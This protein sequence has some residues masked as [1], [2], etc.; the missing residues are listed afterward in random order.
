MTTWTRR[1]VAAVATV[2]V[3][4]LLAPAAQVSAHSGNQ[5]YLY[6]DVTERT[7]GGRIEMPL[8]DLRDTLGVDLDGSNDDIEASLAAAA[9]AIAAFL[10]EHFR[11]GTDGGRWPVTYGTPTVFLSDLPEAD[12]RY[13][14]VDFDVDTGGGEVP[15]RFDVMFDPFLTADDAGDNLL[16]IANDWAGGVIENG[17]RVLLAFTEPGTTRTVDLGDASWTNTFEESLRLGVDHIRTGPDHILFV[18]VLLLPSVLVWRAAWLPARSFGA[19]LW[20]ITKIVTMFT[21]AHT[22]TF[23]LA[24]LDV[25]PLPPSKLTESII[26]LSIAAAAL[27]NLR[28]I[29]TNKEWSIAFVFGLFHGMGFAGLVGDLDV[30]RWTQLLSLAGR[31]L[32]IELGQTVVVLV[33]FPMLFLLRRT[34]YYRH[35]L[36]VGS[37]GLAIVSLGWLIERVFEVDLRVGKVVDPIVAWPRSLVAMVILTAVAAV[38]RSVEE[39]AGRLLPVD[40]APVVEEEPPLLEPVPSA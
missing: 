31:N 14:V 40:G 17:E 30:S 16:L 12:D 1:L 2:L 5:S 22:I 18:L 24:G 10:D 37:V 23:S 7:L 35:L 19:S 11:I 27:H 32:G 25:L 4:V 21:L 36:V 39:R 3:M 33:A 20:R 6:L 8:G 34:W 38:L 28:P 13:A 26:A 29:A 9:P 15:R